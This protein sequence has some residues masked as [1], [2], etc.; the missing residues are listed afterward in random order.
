MIVYLHGFNSSPQSFKARLLLACL[1]ELGREAEF[2]APD[3]S[4]WPR[5]A[6][7]TAQ[8]LLA[9]QDPRDVLLIGSSLGGYYAT[10]LAER[11]GMRAVLINPAIR[12]YELLG[13]YLGTQ[14]NLYSGERYALTRAHLEQLRAYDVKAITHP[15]RYLLLVA[16]ADEVLDSRIALQKYCGATQVIDP[17]GDHGFSDFARYTE[18]ILAFGALPRAPGQVAR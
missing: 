7:D 2:A 3:L 18:R 4:H 16:M 9:D 15:E 14:T 5:H 8:A 11:Y 10:W 13:G 17:A 6:M 1:R 12:P